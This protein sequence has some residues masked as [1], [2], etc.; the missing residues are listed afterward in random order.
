MMAKP[1][2]EAKSVLRSYLA[3]Q[4]YGSWVAKPPVSD[5]FSM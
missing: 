1:Y 2:Q 4:G 5:H 3:Q